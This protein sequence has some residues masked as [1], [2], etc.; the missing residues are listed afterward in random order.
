MFGYVRPHEPELKICEFDAYKAV[1]CGLCKQMGREYG[2]FSRFTLNYDFTFLAL[3]G[4]A[5]SNEKFSLKPQ[6]CIANPVKKRLCFEK[7]EILSFSSSVAMLM[8]Y[9][10]IQ[11]NLH[12]KKNIAKI[13]SVLIK[14][15]AILK[16]KKAAKKI[17]TVDEI[18]K[19][20]ME[21]QTQAETKNST[22]DTCAHPTSNAMGLICC[23]LYKIS[24]ADS[25]TL[26][27]TL[28]NM[29]QEDETQKNAQNKNSQTQKNAQDKNNQTQNNVQ[30]KNSQTREILYRF[31]YLLGR[32][33]YFADALDDME[34]DAKTGSFN[35]FLNKYPNEKEKIPEYAKEVIN[36]TISQLASAYELLEIH[37]F[38]PI[39][40]KVII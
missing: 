15:F 35:P 36:L 21:S 27:D 28:N 7:N 17:D 37:N 19:Q 4:M 39:L 31:G 32:Y 25:F 38:K 29:P 11:D 16:H 33:V 20:A 24:N 8:I 5:L 3:L 34:K 14:P 22:I 23:E 12:D 40:D 10:K 6:I 2:F 18:I 30:N 1:Y 9:Y 26:K 13:P